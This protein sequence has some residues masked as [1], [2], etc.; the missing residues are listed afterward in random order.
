MGMRE[1]IKALN[2]LLDQMLAG[3]DRHNDH[4]LYQ[5]DQ[6]VNMKEQLERLKKEAEHEPDNVILEEGQGDYEII[7]VDRKLN[8][9]MLESDR[10]E[11]QRAD[12]LSLFL[13]YVEETKKAIDEMGEEPATVYRDIK[14]I[15]YM[16]KLKMVIAEMQDRIETENFD[17]DF[18]DAID[19]KQMKKIYRMD[20]E[21]V[22][23][24]FRQ[25]QAVAAVKILKSENTS[26]EIKN[27]KHAIRQAVKNGTLQQYSPVIAFHTN[28]G[29]VRY[30]MD[31]C[32]SPV[33]VVKVLSQSERVKNVLD[34]YRNAEKY[35][36]GSALTEEE[37][38]A[39]RRAF[40]ECYA[41]DLGGLYEALNVA[42]SPNPEKTQ[43]Q[44]LEILK[45]NGLDGMMRDYHDMMKDRKVQDEVAQA[46]SDQK[47]NQ[48]ANQNEEVDVEQNLN[49]NNEIERAAQR[50]RGIAPKDVRSYL[51]DAQM[52]DEEKAFRAHKTT[53][54]LYDAEKNAGNNVNKKEQLLG[55][56]EFHKWIYRRSESVV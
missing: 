55:L 46:D 51:Y 34:Q 40:M 18:S 25:S 9:K 43:S 29:K 50:E 16:L 31:K 26:E 30:D 28:Q 48:K 39:S 13:Q 24:L 33:D 7:E 11:A 15:E 41:A 53:S 1:R 45:E 38:R 8:R 17:G 47:A 49:I 19:V 27:R 12:K 23:S 6:F 3:I 54:V 21:G 10:K 36:Y 20:A 44:I 35:W 2:E 14:A 56:K 22:F 52:T 5:T 32:V 37:E 42:A 4:L